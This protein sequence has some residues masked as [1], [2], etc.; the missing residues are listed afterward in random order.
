[1]ASNPSMQT[2]RVQ[3][4]FCVLHKSGQMSH[5]QTHT[6]TCA[7]WPWKKQHNVI[8]SQCSP[9]VWWDGAAWH[10]SCCLSLICFYLS[11]PCFSATLGLSPCFSGHILAR[12]CLLSSV[13]QHPALHVI[14]NVQRLITMH[15]VVLQLHTFQTQT[16][17][18]TSQFKCCARSARGD[19]RHSHLSPGWIQFTRSQ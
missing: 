18:H 10:L 19:L 6:H 4:G 2:N 7:R 3:N 13:L 5:T 17:T 11:E 12:H 14:V 8:N 15:I 9:S 16:H 1:M